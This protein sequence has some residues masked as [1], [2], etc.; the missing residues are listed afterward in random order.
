MYLVRD[1]V[2]P[3]AAWASTTSPLAAR[4]D[5][6]LRAPRTWPGQ[7]S[8]VAHPGAVSSAVC[9][10]PPPLGT[11]WPSAWAHRVPPCPRPVDPQT[12]TALPPYPVAVFPQHPFIACIYLSGLHHLRSCLFIPLCV[13]DPIGPLSLPVIPFPAELLTSRYWP[14]GC[15][16]YH[17]VSRFSPGRVHLGPIMLLY[18]S[19]TLYLYPHLARHEPMRVR[20]LGLPTTLLMETP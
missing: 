15:R 9:A 10:C 2:R 12:V 16:M 6:P 4:S 17:L 20:V 19:L 1:P 14:S 3:N 11:V 7:P 8:R 13:A 5:L 18:G